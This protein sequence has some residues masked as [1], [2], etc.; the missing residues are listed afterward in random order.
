[1]DLLSAEFNGEVGPAAIEPGEA[2]RAWSRAG[3]AQ[4]PLPQAAVL[5]VARELGAGQVTVGSVVGGGPGRLIVAASILSVPSGQ[6]RVARVQVEGS[7]DSLPALTSGLA[8][9]LLGRAAGITGSR[10]NEAVRTYLEG[11]AAYRK[12]SNGTECSRGACDAETQFLRAAQLDST[13]LL[14]AYRLVLLRALFGPTQGVN[15]FRASFR[16]LW[17]QRQRLSA[18]QRVLLEALAD[19]SGLYF[20]MQALPRM[21]RAVPSL[22][23]SA[24]A[25]DIIGDLYFH[26]GPLIGRED[27]AERSRLAF[28]RAIQ[29]DATLCPC[30]REHLADFAY[31]A[32]DAR[33]FAR[34]TQS[35]P[36]QRYQAAM[37]K[38]DPAGIRGARTEYIRETAVDPHGPS[39]LNGVLPYW[40]TGIPVA[41]HEAD[42]V[43]LH[44]EQLA[45][46]DQ[47]RRTL[48][49][50]RV[51]ASHFAG[52]PGR[53]AEAARRLWSADTVQFYSAML[54][55]VYEDSMAA[56]RL[57]PMLDK[58]ARGYGLGVCNVALARLRHGDTT[59]VRAILGELDPREPDLAELLSIR[60]GPTAQSKVCAQVLRGVLASLQASG[61]PLL[62]RADSLLRFMPLN[63]GD[64]W[65]YDLGLAFARRG[66]F[67]MAASAVRRHPVAMGRWGLPRLVISLRQEGRWAALADDTAAAIRAYRRYLIYREDPEPVL[68]P[69]R[70]SV[71]AELTALE[72]A[73][74]RRAGQP[75]P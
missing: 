12:S 32:G 66:E 51:G 30:A 61:S 40:L 37:L 33:T 74:P 24:E 45:N 4:Q 13:F 67:A 1:M 28:L 6:V 57:L 8:T 65:N 75:R 26:V 19:S 35:T 55:Y 23:N 48:A 25:W 54:D 60:P 41:Q 31:L 14:P 36:W 53:A 56:E 9:Q 15:A 18:E 69:Q 52:R 38:G 73:Y 68:I 2:L 43:L 50:W 29:L 3:G 34:Y 58:R 70:D 64:L 7:E 5:R 44:L 63:Y 21:E 49:L 59:G 47:Q 20:R 71:R 42:S 16:N 27:S 62:F 39:L 10:S 46:S 22:P 17:N 11:M 72:K